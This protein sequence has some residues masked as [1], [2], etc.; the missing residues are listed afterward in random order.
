MKRMTP[1]QA[2]LA[3]TAVVA[4]SVLSRRTAFFSPQGRLGRRALLKLGGLG[5]TA[6]AT[7]A[8]TSR[9]SVARL[10]SGSPSRAVSCVLTPEQTEGPYYIPREQVRK[11]IVAHRPGTPL[12]LQ[13]T[14]V[15]AATCRPLKGAAVDIWHCDAKGIYSGFESA[16]VGGAPGT[17]GPTDKDTF[18][19]GI[20]RTDAR[21]YCEFQTI[22]PG[23]YRGRTT[24]IHV[25]V[26]LGGT[27]VH[28]GQLYF[29][30]SLTDRVYQTGPYKARVAARATRNSDDAIYRNGGRQ[31][32]LTMKRTGQGGYV[33]TITLGVR[34]S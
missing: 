34:R 1:H 13:L 6:F 9:S 12:R 20:Q 31:S 33:G 15:D 25:K 30:D 16:S 24:H 22:Y 17:T 14:V 27:V 2:A 29:P 4:A 3:L 18:L 19:R 10:P 28:T 23:W 7:S 5:L 26:H 8:W 21:G 32:M 11:N